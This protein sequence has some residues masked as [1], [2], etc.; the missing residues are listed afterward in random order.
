MLTNVLS[1]GGKSEKLIAL[2]SQVVANFA[3]GCDSI[4]YYFLILRVPFRFLFCLRIFGTVVVNFFRFLPFL[5]LVLR[6][7]KP[8]GTRLAAP[9]PVFLLLLLLL[10]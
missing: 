1:T 4:Y 7:F 5:F 9:P 10:D 2:F 6:L 3:N 8:A